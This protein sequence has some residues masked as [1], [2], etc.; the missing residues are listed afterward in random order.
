M[1]TLSIRILLR[2]CLVMRKRLLAAGY[3]RDIEFDSKAS[4]DEYLE[5]LGFKCLDY[6]ILDKYTRSDGTVI[7]RI[8]QQYNSA[9]LIEL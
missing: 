5:V 6:R 1:T 3:L 8:L 7:V 2:R 9:D 4:L